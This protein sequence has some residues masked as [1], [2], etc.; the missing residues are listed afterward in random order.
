MQPP[1]VCRPPGRMVPLARILY[2]LSIYL[3]NTYTWRENLG[4]VAGNM[5]AGNMLAAGSPSNDQI[6]YEF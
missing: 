3:Y 6:S 4:A 2:D 5:L 1:E